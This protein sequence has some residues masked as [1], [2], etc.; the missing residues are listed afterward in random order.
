MRKIIS[1]STALC[2]FISTAVNITVH[3]A[4]QASPLPEGW[5]LWHQ[6]SDYAA[7]DSQLFLQKPDGSITEIT[8]AFSHAMNG[9][10]GVT[11]TQITFMALNPAGDAWDIFLYD[12]GSVRNL[13]E[14][15]GFRNE[16]PKWSPDGTQIVFKRG[17]WDSSIN[18]MVYDLA[19]YD[20]ASGEITMLTDDTAEDAMPCFAGDGGSIY[21]T[22]YTGGIGAIYCLDMQSGDAVPVYAKES[23]NAYYPIA[24]GDT[25]YFTKWYS[26]ENHHDQLMR[27]DA[28]GCAALPFNA[29]D[30]DCSDACP[31]GENAMIYS[32]TAQG[33]Y[34]LYYYDGAESY[35]LSRQSSDKNDLGADFYSMTEYRSRVLGDVNADGKTDMADLIHLHKWLAAVPDSILANWAAGDYNLDGKIDSRDFSL[36]KSSFLQAE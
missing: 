5:L 32:G 11:P 28:S 1:L 4:E 21:Y 15:S 17:K 23:V 12:N 33:G 8:G 20:V 9:H 29:P 26:A 10:F 22:R 7:L 14:N 25:L 36:M 24:Y 30:Y 35:R 19:L 2:I 34:D 3:C 31:L 27:Y 6:Y 18:D 13:T 16:D